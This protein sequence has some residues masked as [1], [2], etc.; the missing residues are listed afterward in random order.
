MSK[1][2]YRRQDA[3]GQFALRP[4]RLQSALAAGGIGYVNVVN[5][6]CSPFY[7]PAVVDNM[8]VH[9]DWGHITD[10]YSVWL[11]PMFDPVFRGV[12]K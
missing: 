3:Y 9:R 12:A 1:C 6:F 5:W 7:C 11:A 2:A 8:V 10:T 4:V